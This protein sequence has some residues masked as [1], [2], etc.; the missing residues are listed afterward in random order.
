MTSTLEDLH[1]PLQ[2]VQAMSPDPASSDPAPDG[3]ADGERETFAVL[4]PA[5]GRKIADVVSGSA[6]DVDEAVRRSSEAG[7]G[8]A[9]LTPRRRGAYLRSFA[10]VLRE[11]ADELAALE[12]A[13]NGKPARDALAFDVT[14]AH[15]AFEMFAGLVET[16]TGTLLDQGTIEAHIVREPY[17]VV[18]AI[19]P[20][21]WPPI[22]FAAKCAPALAAGNTVVVKPGDQAPLTVLRLVEL[23][24][25]V[26]PPDVVIAV[27]GPAAGPALA[28]HPG[29]G[30]ITFTGAPGTG[31][32]VMA[33]AAKTLTL[34]TMELGGKNALIVFADA[35]LDVALD[36]SLEG[37]FFNQGEACT[38]TARIL[39]QREVYEEFTSRFVAATARLKVGEGTDADVAIGPMVDARQRDRVL[40]YI[41][42]GKAEGAR[43]VHQGTV[44]DDP[45]L[46][47]GYWVPPTVF[48]DV[49]SSMRIAQEE[50]FGPVAALMPFDTEAEA[51]EIAN[52]TR[53]G[54]TAAVFTRDTALASRC[55]HALQAGMVFVNNYFR[56]ALLGSPFGGVKD[57]GFGS[58]GWVETLHEFTRPKNIRFPSGTAPVP[59]WGPV[60]KAT[61]R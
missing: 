60:A 37:M 56:G 10:A 16:L 33:A 57:S 17:G 27:P 23:A 25:E 53:F 36:A 34:P 41:D 21:N 19:L 4:N 47:G 18:G 46:S 59:V 55:A 29:L 54:L 5:T 42:V 8:W 1:V 45:R 2:W 14:Y 15:L 52:G 51:I 28:A 48:A 58:E 3:V 50:I 30:R 24:A 9:A 6:A 40:G 44:P 7:I 22:H 35:D 31:R 38:S 20:F 49:T 61:A 39:V 11:H 43:L 13:E 12:S 26:F 32:S